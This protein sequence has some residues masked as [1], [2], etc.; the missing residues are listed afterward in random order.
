[1]L[2]DAQIKAKNIYIAIGA[3]SIEG[4]STLMIKLKING[5]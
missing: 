2:K 3:F 4:G 5:C 1:M